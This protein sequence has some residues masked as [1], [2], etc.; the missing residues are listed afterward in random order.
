MHRQNQHVKTWMLWTNLLKKVQA[1]RSLQRE[2]R[3]YEIGLSLVHTVNCLN[4]VLGPTTHFHVGLAIDELSQPPASNGVI[5]DQEDLGL[6]HGFN[7]KR[8]V[9][10]VPPPGSAETLSEPPIVAARCRIISSPLPRP[11]ASPQSPRPLSFTLR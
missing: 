9:M 6:R 10:T 11:E 5:F 1:I 7:G 2:V 3:D 8:Q 4:G